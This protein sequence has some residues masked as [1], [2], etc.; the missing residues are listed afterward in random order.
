MNAKPPRRTRERILERSLELGL[1]AIVAHEAEAA[2]LLCRAL[3]DSGDLAASPAQ[4]AT[5]TTNMAVVATGWLPYE[6]IANAGR[7][8]EPAFQT[9]SV[10]RGTEQALA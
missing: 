8:F 6:Y 2:G 4:I 3:A 7:F 1:Q 9:A 10:E 5:L